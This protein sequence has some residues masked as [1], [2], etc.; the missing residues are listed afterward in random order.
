MSLHLP[1]TFTPIGYFRAVSEKLVIRDAFDDAQFSADETRIV[2]AEKGEWNVAVER[3]TFDGIERNASVLITHEDMSRLTSPPIWKPTPSPIGVDGGSIAI[4]DDSYFLGVF[5]DEEERHTLCRL[6]QAHLMSGIKRGVGVV[7]RGC[8]VETG[9]GNGVYEVERVRV[10]RWLIGLR[11][12]F[13][14]KSSSP[15]QQR[16][17][18][19]VQAQ[20]AQTPEWVP[21]PL[22]ALSLSADAISKVTELVAAAPR[23][24]PNLRAAV[25]RQ[26]KLRG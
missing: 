6:W 7:G 15:D 11:I 20:R 22:P 14:A 12:D 3:I 2:Y 1:P 23:P 13:A 18:T 4:F 8:F 19:A 26:R 5:A 16:F 25:A 9:I 17:F 10:D 24:C 21:V